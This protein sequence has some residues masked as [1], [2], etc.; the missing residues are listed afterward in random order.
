MAAPFSVRGRPT[1]TSFSDCHLLT[2]LMWYL[3]PS[4][5]QEQALRVGRPWGALARGDH[6]RSVVVDGPPALKSR[7]GLWPQLGLPE[8]PRGPGRPSR[9]LCL[10]RERKL[11]DGHCRARR[12]GS[13]GSA[14]PARGVG[15]ACGRA[16]HTAWPGGRTRGRGGPFPHFPARRGGPGRGVG[17]QGWRAAPRG[18]PAGP[19]RPVCGY[20]T[21][22]PSPVAQRAPG[23][24]CCRPR[25]TDRAGSV[26]HRPPWR[27]GQGAR[28]CL[29]P[30]SCP[31]GVSEFEMHHSDLPCLDMEDW[32]HPDAPRPGT[33]RIVTVTTAP[34][35]R[36]RTPPLSSCKQENP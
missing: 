33:A 19:A 20:G 24:P 32:K 26:T 35:G 6:S 27:E 23:P 8:G 4:V 7:P 2:W 17:A 29:S 13:S 36:R 1:V 11:Q 31:L 25:V 12:L 21:G 3:S 16:C 15:L 28:T 22:A 18:Q 5:P 34:G 14:F 10:N 30:S 9:S